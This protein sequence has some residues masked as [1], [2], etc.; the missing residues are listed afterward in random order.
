MKLATE[1]DCA[2]FLLEQISD[3]LWSYLG[4]LLLV[5][6]TLYGIF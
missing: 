4:D 1:L 5:S 3:I 6:K 2:Q